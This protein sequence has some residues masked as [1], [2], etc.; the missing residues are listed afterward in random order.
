MSLPLSVLIVLYS[1]R[2]E[3]DMDFMYNKIAADPKVYYS[4]SNLMCS[5]FH[6]FNCKIIRGRKTHKWS[7]VQPPVYKRIIYTY[8][9]LGE[10][11]QFNPIRIFITNYS[12]SIVLYVDSINSRI[13]A[14]NLLELLNWNEMNNWMT[15]SMSYLIPQTFALFIE[16]K[17]N[18]DFNYK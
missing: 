4:W 14:K 1:H 18:D 16:L 11:P 2:I 15:M 7:S 10:Y 13:C 12:Y 3:I 9:V 6:P 8:T 5:L 17:F